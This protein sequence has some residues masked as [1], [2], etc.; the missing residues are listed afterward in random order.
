ML[1]ALLARPSVAHQRLPGLLRLTEEADQTWRAELSVPVVSGKPLEVDVPAPS[2]CTGSSPRLVQLDARR[3]LQEASW[4]CPDGR[5]DGRTV[6]ARGLVGAGIELVVEAQLAHGDPEVALL[7][8]D[9]PTWTLPLRGSSPRQGF[10]RGLGLPLR[11]PALGLLAGLVGT[12]APPRRA[13]ACLL[14]AGLGVWVGGGFPPTASLGILALPLL[15][16]GMVM[17][18]LLGRRARGTELAM[19]AALGGLLLGAAALESLG[20][21]AR[22]WSVSHTSLALGSLASCLALAIPLAWWVSPTGPGNIG[23]RAP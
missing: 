19:A 9:A 8:G 12:L 17:A 21:G 15:L 23:L 1:L 11:L 3:R 18:A 20:P 6:E 4:T 7:R 10:L 2:G 13:A 14:L 5:I 22:P 16:T